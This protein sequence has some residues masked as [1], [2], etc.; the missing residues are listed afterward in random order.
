MERCASLIE[1]IVSIAIPTFNQEAY[2]EDCLESILHNQWRK[3][4][5]II[6]DDA[7]NDR[8][9]EKVQRWLSLHP[10]IPSTFVQHSQNRG[11]TKTLNE[12]ILHSRGTYFCPIAGDDRLLPKGIST[13]MKFLEDHPSM[14]AVFGNCHL[15]DER[16]DLITTDGMK[17]RDGG[18]S[19]LFYRNRFLLP[20]ALIF[21]WSVLG[22]SFFCR[23]KMFEQ[24]G[25]YDEKLHFE[26][27]EMFLRL[28]SRGILG[29]VEDPVAEYRVHSRST[30]RNVGPKILQGRIQTAEA[31]CPYFTGIKRH[32]LY[33]RAHSPFSKDP[34]IQRKLNSTLYSLCKIYFWGLKQCVH[35]F[36]H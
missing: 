21:K 35:L 8:T 23:T 22:P 17:M 11:I 7:S 31:A 15:I 25:G 3:F 26:D 33:Y 27:W 28:A 34:W 5:L 16:G 13:R 19:K 10:E 30:S 6:I 12:L 32:A 36:S 9:V 4:E 29:Y 24:I 20:Y 2:I 18:L 14:E 1:D